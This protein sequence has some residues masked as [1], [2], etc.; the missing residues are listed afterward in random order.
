MSVPLS[1]KPCD[2]LCWIA[3]VRFVLQLQE[4]FKLDLFDLSDSHGSKCL[5]VTWKVLYKLQLLACTCLYCACIDTWLTILTNYL[6]K[7]LPGWAMN[8]LADPC[9]PIKLNPIRTNE[10]TFLWSAVCC[11]LPKERP[12]LSVPLHKLVFT[13][14]VPSLFLVSFSKQWIH[15]WTWY[16]DRINNNLYRSTLIH[17]HMLSKN[18]CRASV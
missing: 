18:Y 3:D 4:P 14:M 12:G 2:L 10:I 16:K 6:W 11:V 15:N 7:V 9:L 13:T 17:V 5:R 1:V 8:Y